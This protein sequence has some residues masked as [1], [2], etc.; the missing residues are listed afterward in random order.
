M[1]YIKKPIVWRLKP[2]KHLVLHVANLNCE[3]GDTIWN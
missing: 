2:P 3:F 1:E